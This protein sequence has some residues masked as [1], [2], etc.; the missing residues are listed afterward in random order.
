MTTGITVN[1]L[2]TAAAN[3]ERLIRLI[4]VTSSSMRCSPLASLD[5]L[6]QRSSRHRRLLGREREPEQ[7]HHDEAPGVVA[8]VDQAVEERCEVP[9]L[10]P[11][12]ADHGER[13]QRTTSGCG[14]EHLEVVA[15]RRRDVVL[16]GM[17]DALD[18]LASE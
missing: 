5:R 7:L 10:R 8:R 12:L 4:N 6:R 9:G 11:Q 15:T 16:A 2:P 17:T 13:G 18:D 1:T 3:C 14:A